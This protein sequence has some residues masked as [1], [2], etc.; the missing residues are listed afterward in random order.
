[1]LLGC[2]VACGRPTRTA[3]SDELA[4]AITGYE[5][6]APDASEDRIAALFARLDADIA[7]ARADEL[8]HAPADR[9]ELRQRREA[10]ESTRSE[11]QTRYLKA[12]V[13]RLGETAND[14]LKQLRDQLGRGLEDAGRKL[15]DSDAHPGNAPE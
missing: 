2:V 3:T 10:L 11:L 6:K 13:A 9:A 15:R 12:R 5:Q 8:A 7:T 1:V 14:T 4:A